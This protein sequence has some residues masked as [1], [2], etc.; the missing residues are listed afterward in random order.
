MH[1]GYLPHPEKN[2]TLGNF[3]NPDRTQHGVAKAKP[4]ARAPAPFIEHRGPNSASGRSVVFGSFQSSSRGTRRRSSPGS[5]LKCREFHN[6]IERDNFSNDY[7]PLP[8]GFVR[9][10]QM[11]DTDRVPVWPLQTFA[12]PL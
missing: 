10:I 8:F 9:I 4:G 1:S 7:L 5:H 3:R 11:G 2:A 12:H 6:A